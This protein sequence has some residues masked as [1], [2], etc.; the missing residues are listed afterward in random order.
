MFVM[1]NMSSCLLKLVNSSTSV[2]KQN[3]QTKIMSV[4][5][6]N[7]KIAFTSTTAYHAEVYD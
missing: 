3:I 2:I 1:I 7:P 6:I 4:R 5:N